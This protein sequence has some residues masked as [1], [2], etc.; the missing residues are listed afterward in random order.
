MIQFDLR[1]RNQ[2]AVLGLGAIA[3]YVP[4]GSYKVGPGSSYN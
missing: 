2:R 4:F 1:I 3:E